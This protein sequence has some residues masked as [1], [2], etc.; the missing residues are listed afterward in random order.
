MFNPNTLSPAKTLTLPIDAATTLATARVLIIGVGGLGCAVAHDLALAGVGCLVL[1]DF[2]TVDLSNLQRQLLH[3][4]S[5]IGQPKVLSAQRALQQLAPTVNILPIA[6]HLT[7][8]ELLEEVAAADVVLDCS[9][10]FAT[11]FMLNAACVQQRTPLI[12]GASIE[13]GG[14]VASFALNTA[15]A[16]CYHCLYPDEAEEAATTCTQNGVLAPLVGIIG[17]LQATEAV[18]VLLNIGT[19]LYAR[20]LL[21]DA[22]TARW[23]VVNLVK[24]PACPVCQHTGT[25]SPF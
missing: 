18:K 12:S 21:F 19:P 2:D 11:R 1:V 4:V 14:Q 7:E 10:N 3:D 24:D 23:R 8:K 9:D 20:L 15:D 16:P 25:N 17:S 13:F 6:Q 5:Q 22:L